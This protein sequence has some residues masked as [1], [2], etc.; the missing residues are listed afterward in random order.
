MGM[1]MGIKHVSWCVFQFVT[2]DEFFNKM[3][4][5]LQKHACV[6][7]VDNIVFIIQTKEIILVPRE[8]WE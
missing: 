6:Q 4:K 3:Y 1:A 2:R 7:V 8:L 5:Q